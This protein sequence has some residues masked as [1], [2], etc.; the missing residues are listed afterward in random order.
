MFFGEGRFDVEHAQLERAKSYAVN[1]PYCLARVSRAQA[2][3]LSRQHRF[4]EEKSEA[5]HAFDLFV[6][7][8][9]AGDVE[10]TRRINRDAR[11]KGHGFGYTSW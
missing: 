4:E 5:L 6:R 10:T 2:W 8:G 9:A 7:F 1:D 11:G 3:L